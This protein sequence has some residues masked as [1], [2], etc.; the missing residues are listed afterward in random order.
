MSVMLFDAAKVS[1]KGGA[2]CGGDKETSGTSRRTEENFGRRAE[3]TGRF[4]EGSE[5]ICRSE[6]YFNG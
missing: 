3:E 2:S 4:H 1:D 6:N 5:G